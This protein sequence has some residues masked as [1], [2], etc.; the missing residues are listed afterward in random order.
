MFYVLISEILKCRK[1]VQFKTV[2]IIYHDVKPVLTFGYR[3]IESLPQIMELNS[4]I[5]NFPLIKCITKVD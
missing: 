2:E 5:N 1:N 4:I 3:Y